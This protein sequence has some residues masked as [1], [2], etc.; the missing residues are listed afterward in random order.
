[1]FGEDDFRVFHCGD[2]EV[3]CEPFH[4]KFDPRFFIGL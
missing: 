4:A 3:I 2:A 1:M